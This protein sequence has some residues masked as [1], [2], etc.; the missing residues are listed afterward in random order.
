M[1]HQYPYLNDTERAC[2]AREF[3]RL[4]LA[5][6]VATHAYP[7]QIMKGT[8]GWLEAFSV[9]DGKWMVVKKEK[10]ITEPGSVSQILIR[11]DVGF[12]DAIH[13]LAQFEAEKAATGVAPLAQAPHRHYKT[14]AEGAGL[15][16]D[17]NRMPHPT[18][19]GQILGDAT[20]E[21]AVYDRADAMAA[22]RAASMQSP[23]QAMVA[24][25]PLQSPPSYFNESMRLQELI[26]HMAQ[27]NSVLEAILDHYNGINHNAIRFGDMDDS[28]GN[29]LDKH[30]ATLQQKSEKLI[31][32]EARSDSY[33]PEVLSWL[34]QVITAHRYVAR[35][36]VA[37]HTYATSNIVAGKYED[38]Y[39]RKCIREATDDLVTL[40]GAAQDEAQKTVERHVIAATRSRRVT[41]PSEITRITGWMNELRV[42]FIDKGKNSR[43][44]P[45]DTRKRATSLPFV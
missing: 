40:T 2:L 20:F 19:M 7:D 11:R 22:K 12:F 13:A 29:V 15:V 36:S 5:G 45:F 14:V 34:S 23:V 4:A 42:H 25:P 1:E 18:M 44:P 32:A 21:Q 38:K 26:D 37:Q 39:V 16:F 31:Q 41:M 10:S 3:T 27:T 17:I 6:R 43:T 9:R 8:Q 30:L 24:Q 28:L 35:I 33:D